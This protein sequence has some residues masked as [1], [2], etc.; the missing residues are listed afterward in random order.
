MN[1]QDSDARQYTS[2]TG[3][4]GS[5]ACTDRNPLNTGNAWKYNACKFR[6]KKKKIVALVDQLKAQFVN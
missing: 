2:F 3:F 1:R 6:K 4:Q 5:K